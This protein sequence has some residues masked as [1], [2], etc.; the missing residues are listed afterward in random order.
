MRLRTK[1]LSALLGL[2]YEA[3]LDPARWNDVLTAALP[4]MDAVNANF[5]ITDPR[6]ALSRVE[7]AAGID[8]ALSRAYDAY[9]AQLNVIIPAVAKAGLLH[10]GSVIVADEVLSR[11]EFER[12]EYFR[13]FLE[14][15]DCITVLGAAIL[16]NECRSSLI[17]FQRPRSAGPVSDANVANLR[18]LLPHLQRAQDIHRHLADTRLQRDIQSTALDRLEIGLVLFGPDGRILL[19]NRAAEGI[20]SERDGLTLCSVGPQ[21][22]RADENALLGALLAAVLKTGNRDGVEAGGVMLVS[23]PSGRR[24]FQ[25]VVTPLALPSPGP[26]HPSAAAALFV[27]DPERSVEDIERILRRLYAL[28][29]AEARVTALLVEGKSPEEAAEHLQVSLHTVRAQMKRIFAKTETRRQSEL[30]RLVLAGLAV[31]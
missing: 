28:T 16:H 21:A 5:L 30:I 8:P 3:A 4:A 1:E 2:V 27:C 18:L 12:S 10:T 9:Y 19:V 26:G 6:S 7:A 15:Q 31:R 20:F 22:S 23:R 11:A 25:V 24:P 13:D 14:P 17:S 29:P